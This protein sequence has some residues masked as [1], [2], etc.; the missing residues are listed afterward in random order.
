MPSQEPQSSGDTIY[1]TSQEPTQYHEK[2]ND[3]QANQSQPETA[4]DVSEKD[5][6]DTE[7][8]SAESSAQNPPSSGKEC[9]IKRF[10]SEQVSVVVEF[11]T[12]R[13]HLGY[14]RT[15]VATAV[16]GTVVAQL[17]ALQASGTGLGYTA[18]GKPLATLCY[19]FSICIVSLGAFRAWRLQRAMFAGKALAG[20]FEL[21]TLALG[22]L[23]LSVIFFGFLI[24][25]DVVKESSG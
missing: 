7:A 1:I 15:S 16:L 11:E 25:L 19:S 6:D 22:F 12:C 9:A 17:F 8:S 18:V 10:W 24:A 2:Q 5:K 13:D 3:D 14:L 4:R 23:A 21:T 20:G